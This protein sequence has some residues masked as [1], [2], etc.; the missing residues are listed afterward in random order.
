MPRQSSDD[1]VHAGRIRPRAAL[2]QWISFLQYNHAV[3]TPYEVLKITFREGLPR[4][5]QNWR[6]RRC[7][8]AGERVGNP[9]ANHSDLRLSRFVLRNPAVLGSCQPRSQFRLQHR[10]TMKLPPRH[11]WH[12]KETLGLFGPFEGL[13]VGV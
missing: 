11:L 8:F 13:A 12:D 10:K 1:L 2:Q 9:C 5:L 3:E 6:T 4:D 7:I